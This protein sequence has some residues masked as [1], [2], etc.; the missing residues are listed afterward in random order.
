VK[1]IPVE[2]TMLEAIGYDEEAQVLSV[3]FHSGGLYNYYDV[4][5]E[6]YEGLLQAESKGQYMHAWVIDQYPYSRGR[7]RESGRR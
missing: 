6:V 7:I 1:L 4:P 3:I 2:S 5:R